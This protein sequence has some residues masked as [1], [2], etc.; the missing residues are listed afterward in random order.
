MDEKIGTI[1]EVDIL[2]I[3]SAK[4]FMKNNPWIKIFLFL[5]KREKVQ[6]SEFRDIS[7]SYEKLRRTANRL[8]KSGF[9]ET[10]KKGNATSYKLS[11]KGT[12]IIEKLEE[13]ENILSNE[14]EISLEDKE[15]LLL[16]TTK[17]KNQ[18]Q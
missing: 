6:T 8:A 10:E 9:I 15:M 18:N 4:R 1:E 2:P 11:E 17:E 7:G 16:T 14:R 3:L 5:D 13:I 12:D